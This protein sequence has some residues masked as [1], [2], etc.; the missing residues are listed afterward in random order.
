MF[1]VGHFPLCVGSH[2]FATSDVARKSPQNVARQKLTNVARFGLESSSLH[3][4]AQPWC[5]PPW[6][7]SNVSNGSQVLIHV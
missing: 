6:R 5:N 2:A 1:L 3:E 4:K 7:I